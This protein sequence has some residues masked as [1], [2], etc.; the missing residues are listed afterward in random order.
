MEEPQ[1]SPS[2]EE[3]PKDSHKISAVFADGTLTE[4]KLV[5]H[6]HQVAVKI[7]DKGINKASH[8]TTDMDLTESG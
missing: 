4:M 1:D 7:L 6:I 5:C 8:S 3:T 2:D